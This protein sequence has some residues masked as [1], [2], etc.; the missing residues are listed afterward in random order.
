MIRVILS[1]ANDEMVEEIDAHGFASF[2]HSLRES[3]VIRTGCWIVGRMIMAKSQDSGVRQD[4]F[5]DDDAHVNRRFRNSSMT[6]ALGSD[7]FVI[8]VH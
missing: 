4:G 8:L 7:K 6:D 1:V 3:V 5:L 2:L